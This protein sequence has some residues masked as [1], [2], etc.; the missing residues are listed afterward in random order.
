MLALL[1]PA[2][3]RSLIHMNINLVPFS[4]FLFPY[5]FLFLFRYWGNQCLSLDIGFETIVLLIATI[6][7]NDRM[8]ISA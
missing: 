2:I 4:L 5:S 7:Q 1:S 6:I 3:T 8:H